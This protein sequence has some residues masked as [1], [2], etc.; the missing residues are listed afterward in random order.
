[1]F[2]CYWCFSSE[3]DYCSYLFRRLSLLLLLCWV[4]ASFLECWTFTLRLHWEISVTNLLVIWNLSKPR[5][6]DDV[7]TYMQHILQLKQSQ[8]QQ[9][10][11]NFDLIVL[12]C[13]RDCVWQLFLGRSLTSIS[14]CCHYDLYY[15]SV[16]RTHGDQTFSLFKLIQNQIYQWRSHSDAITYSKWSKVHDS[17]RKCISISVCAI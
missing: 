14:E 12:I 1:M 3:S 9:Q 10:E 17:K 15:V 4:F 11:V 6:I 5:Y 16:V 8:W 7:L 2:D 13:F